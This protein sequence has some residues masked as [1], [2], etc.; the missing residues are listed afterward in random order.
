[1]RLRESS[2]PQLPPRARMR[3]PLTRRVRCGDAADRHSRTAGEVSPAWVSEAAQPRG[4]FLML[5]GGFDERSP[6]ALP[7][8]RRLRRGAGALASNSEK[9]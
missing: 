7:A 1:M 2:M 9:S 5:R 8:A 3:T 6:R 4:V